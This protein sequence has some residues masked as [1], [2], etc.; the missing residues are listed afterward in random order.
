M[1]T[2]TILKLTHIDAVVKVVNNTGSSA[3][4]TISLAT[5]LLRSDETLSGSLDVRLSTVE[6]G[7][8]SGG[9]SIVRNAVDV[10]ELPAT[11]HGMFTYE[12]GNDPTQKDQ[13]IVV[14]IGQ[15]TCFIRLL[16]VSG[17]SPNFKP[18]QNGGY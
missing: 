8:G 1:V 17:Y 2:K 5:D 16:K 9:G 3:S 12:L 11:N 13:D 14:T 15:G 6:Y 10:L 7:I 18:E 4:V